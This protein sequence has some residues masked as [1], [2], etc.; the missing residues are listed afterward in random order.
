M[1]FLIKK[2]INTNHE[3]CLIWVILNDGNE[4]LV[5]VCH[6]IARGTILHPVD[7]LFPS[8]LE[9]IAHAQKA[10]QKGR[11]FGM[12]VHYGNKVYK[13]FFVLFFCDE[14]LR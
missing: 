13:D 6:H 3:C 5:G 14:I 7:H 8:D 12:G 11:I 9:G 2:S 4:Q 10:R 1:V